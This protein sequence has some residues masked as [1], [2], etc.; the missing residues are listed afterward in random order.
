[1]CHMTY[2]WAFTSGGQAI[3]NSSGQAA[4][5]ETPEDCCC[6]ICP[7]TEAITVHVPEAPSDLGCTDYSCNFLSKT[8][9]AT[10]VDISLTNCAGVQ[11]IPKSVYSCYNDSSG[12]DTLAFEI[13]DA[14]GGMVT[15]RVVLTIR[16]RE[17]ISGALSTEVYQRIVWEASVSAAT[18][19]ADCCAALADLTL[20]FVS[21][22]VYV[23]STG[24]P[25]TWPSFYDFSAT[26]VTVECQT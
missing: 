24:N 4:I 23:Y 18:L 14:G 8:A 15:V 16:G 3:F 20:S 19:A 10:D 17:C 26:T 1:M 2:K 9:S 7:C 13:V 6:W 22:G 11:T 21:S 5:S 12:Y 25:S